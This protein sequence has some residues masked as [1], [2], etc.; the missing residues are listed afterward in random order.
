MTKT[1]IHITPLQ[2]TTPL[3]MCQLICHGISLS[4]QPTHPSSCL[5]WK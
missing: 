5:D 3:A 4:Q 2:S 1:L